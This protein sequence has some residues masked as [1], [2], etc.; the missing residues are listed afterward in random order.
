MKV[1]S[2]ESIDYLIFCDC[3][4]IFQYRDNSISTIL[5]RN[6]L[7]LNGT[8]VS[9]THLRTRTPQQIA[10]TLVIPYSLHTISSFRGTERTKVEYLGFEF[11]SE[12]QSITDSN[13][14]GSD[15]ISLFVPHIVSFLGEQ[16]FQACKYLRC[17]T[18]GR[19][20]SLQQLGREVFS[21]L[22]YLCHITIPS[23]VKHIDDSAFNWCEIHTVNVSVRSNSNCLHNAGAFRLEHLRALGSS[24]Q[25][26]SHYR[27]NSSMKAVT[28]VCVTIAGF[29]LTVAS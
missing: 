14:V 20:S 17:V 29:A 7:A 18:V 8:R 13:L 19:Q 25:S 24:N 21:E 5:P 1:L 15:L 3:K 28:V 12:F 16:V 2:V 11:G 23:N 10:K 6:C 22:G 9:V 26:L 27:S 4:A